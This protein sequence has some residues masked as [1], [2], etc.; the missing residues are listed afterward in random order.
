[1]ARRGLTDAEVRQRLLDYSRRPYIKEESRVVAPT[2]IAALSEEEA[3]VAL[4]DFKK[5]D[6]KIKRLE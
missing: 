4:E 6:R 1:M 5:V 2:A 3:R